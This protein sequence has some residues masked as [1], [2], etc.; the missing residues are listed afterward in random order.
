MTRRGVA[1]LAA[2]IA[3][4]FAANWLTSRFEQ[5]PLP[6]TTLDVTAGTYAAGAALL[7]RDAVQEACGARWVFAGIAAGAILTAAT[8][9]AL[10]LASTVAFVVAEVLDTAVYTPL[11]EHGWALAALVSGCVG[12]LADTVA[13][14]AIAGFPLT[15]ASVVGQLVGKIVWATAL[16]VASFLALRQV[17]RAAVSRDAV[18]V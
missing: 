17:H 15:A 12:A 16:P 3:A 18:G 10:A 11:R 9:P 7:L 6:G 1:A 2:Y 13:F 8:S 5:V 14:L 4:I